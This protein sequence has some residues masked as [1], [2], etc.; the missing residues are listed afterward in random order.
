LF[1]LLAAVAS[2][3]LITINSLLLESVIILILSLI[4]AFLT[5]R[6]FRIMTE[7]SGPRSA[8]AVYSA[9]MA[10]AAMGFIAVSGI[11]IPLLGIRVTLFL[12]SALIFAGFLFGTIRNK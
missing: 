12:L 11:A 10:G 7:K 2:D 9:D 6:I 4:P 1:Y 8:S 3:K 5:G